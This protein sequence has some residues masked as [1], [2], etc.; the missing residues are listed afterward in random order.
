MVTVL[1]LDEGLFQQADLFVKLAHLAFDH[2]LRDVRRLAAGDGP[3]K[4]DV[5][6]AGKIFRGN[7]FPADVLRIAGGD[8]HGNVVHQLLEVLGASHEIALAVNLHEHADLAAGVDVAGHRA[9]AGHAGCLLRRHG[10]TLLAQDHNRLFHV[11]LGFRQGL[12]AIHHWRSGLLPELF[13]LR[14]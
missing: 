6:F 3:R 7:V 1:I 9:F 5:L 2:F 10:N 8:V 14:S 4:R 13:H 11:A 12:F